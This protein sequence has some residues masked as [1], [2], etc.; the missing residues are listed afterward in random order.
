[1]TVVLELAA[2]G[3]LLLS[4]AWLVVVALRRQSAAVRAG[5]WTAALAGLLVLPLASFAAPAWRVPVW[6]TPAAPPATAEQVPAVTAMRLSAPAFST[7]RR[8]QVDLNKEWVAVT[9]VEPADPTRIDWSVIALLALATGTL[10]LVARVALSHRRLATIVRAASP[11]DTEWAA[12]AAEVGMSLGLKR[13]VPVRITD[14]MNVPAVAGIRQ[15]VLV[16]PIEAREWAPGVRRAVVVHELAHIARRDPLSQL[17]SQLTCAA[18]WFVPLVWFGARRAAALRERACDDVVLAAGI[19]PS[20]YAESLIALV[21][22]ASAPVSPAVVAMAQPSRMRERV[23]AILNPALRRGRVTRLAIVTTSVVVGVATAA[24]GV[25][26]P[27]TVEAAA[28]PI[29]V[30][31]LSAL[32]NSKG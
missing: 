28:R 11:A 22:S 17:T 26:E 25:I 5:V 9:S 10:V 7:V 2:R 4:L 3:L 13:S 20:S 19:R 21:R 12:L 16:L 24:L 32:L 30:P 29:G 31:A 1:M 6:A 18:Y 27:T 14:A 8:G 23:E 15:P